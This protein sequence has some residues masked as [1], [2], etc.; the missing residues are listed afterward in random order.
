MF[1]RAVDEDKCTLWIRASTRRLCVDDMILNSARTG[2]SSS[3]LD[4]VDHRR[5]TRED[6]D[7][8]SYN[9]PNHEAVVISLLALSDYYKFQCEYLSHFRGFSLP[10]HATATVGMVVK[11][12]S[13][14]EVELPVNIA[15][16]P[17]LDVSDPSWS[18]DWGWSGL[19]E[20]DLAG[21]LMPD[22]WRRYNLHQ[23][24][25]AASKGSIHCGVFFKCTEIWLSQ[26]NHIFSSLQIRSN[27]NQY[28]AHVNLILLLPLTMH[29]EVVIRGVMFTWAFSPTTRSSCPSQGWLFVCPDAQL[30]SGPCS[31]RWP[32]C[33]AYWS[34]DPFGTV[35][36]SPEEAEEAGFPL[37][38][39]ELM[40][41]GDSWDSIDYAE[42]WKFHQ[43]KGFA[44]DSQEIARHLGHPLYQLCDEVA[45]ETPFAHGIEE[46]NTDQHDAT[47]MSTMSDEHVYET[48]DS[49]HGDEDEKFGDLQADILLPSRGFRFLFKLPTVI[50]ALGVLYLYLDLLNTL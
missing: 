41:R 19:C 12:D 39:L 17:L 3:Y 24:C 21:D 46:D 50:L 36:L 13:N 33:A 20:P 32:D 48:V 37:I 5:P 35:R 49:E 28:G 29:V 40:V 44:P 16:L 18:W 6:I 1:N 45:V 4:S 31:F 22:S 8:I 47:N 42:L 15:F 7:R 30:H 43:A 10:A 14:F 38:T 11:H 34:H 27:H 23:I 2:W 25:A 9:G 26:A